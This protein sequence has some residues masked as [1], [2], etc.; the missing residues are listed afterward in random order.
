MTYI[1]PNKF[2]YVQFFYIHSGE[3]QLK[4]LKSSTVN[5][6]ELFIIA[7]RYEFIHTENYI[8]ILWEIGS[9]HYFPATIIYKKVY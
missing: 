8:D 9:K 6:F 3:L 4:K 2:S 7:S 1:C 5:K